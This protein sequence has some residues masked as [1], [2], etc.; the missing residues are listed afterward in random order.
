MGNVSSLIKLMR[1][2]IIRN[3]LL[4]FSFEKFP[5]TYFFK[6]FNK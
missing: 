4:F 1:R 2:H 6:D 5:F 3:S